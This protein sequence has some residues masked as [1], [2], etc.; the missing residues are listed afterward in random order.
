MRK[1]FILFDLPEDEP[2]D[3]S[4]MNG[5][6]L[7]LVLTQTQKATRKLDE[8]RK[9]SLLKREEE[10]VT[11]VDFVLVLFVVVL[12]KNR[13]INYFWSNVMYTVGS[14]IQISLVIDTL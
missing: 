10:L 11:I 6:A 12:V 7:R 9:G 13:K 2:P 1:P 3:G 4:Y 5:F 14:D 8:C